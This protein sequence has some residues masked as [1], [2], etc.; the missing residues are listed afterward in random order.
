M[1]VSCASGWP[2]IAPE[3]GQTQGLSLRFQ[4]GSGEGRTSACCP[5]LG[6][7]YMTLLTTEARRVK[8]WAKGPSQTF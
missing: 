2:G 3:Q 1:P 6:L 5:R 4:E 7:T 8:Q